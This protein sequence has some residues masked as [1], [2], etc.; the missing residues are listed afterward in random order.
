MP[1]IQ[2]KTQIQPATPPKDPI[3]ALV[4]SLFLFG[5]AGQIYLGQTDEGHRLHR[6]HGDTGCLVIGGLFMY[7]ASLTPTSSPRCSRTARPS[8]SGSSSGRNSLDS[9]NGLDSPVVDR[10]KQESSDYRTY[11]DYLT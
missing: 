9:P 6:R 8:A 1:L 11:L 2:S 7:S 4:L 3:I 10:F 5:G